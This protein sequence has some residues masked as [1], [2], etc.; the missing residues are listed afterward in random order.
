M[1]SP[2]DATVTVCPTPPSLDEDAAMNDESPREHQ[3]DPNAP[4]MTCD[5]GTLSE[6]HHAPAQEL[7]PASNPLFVAAQETQLPAP[8]IDPPSFSEFICSSDPLEDNIL[9]LTQD[10]RPGLHV[11]PNPSPEPYFGPTIGTTHPTNPRPATA[12]QTMAHTINQ[13][14]P[15]ASH[16][17]TEVAELR[18]ENKEL[19]TITGGLRGDMDRMDNKITKTY[20]LAIDNLERGN[21]TGDLVKFIHLQERLRVKPTPLSKPLPGRPK[22]PIPAM[23]LPRNRTPT[24]SQITTL[25][26]P[27]LPPPP[28]V[29]IISSD[30]DNSQPSPTSSPA[31]ALAPAPTPAPTR[32]QPPRA[33]SNSP[34]SYLE[35][36]PSPPDMPTPKKPC[37]APSYASA[38]QRGFQVVVNK[39]RKSP[40]KSTQPA[41]E[42]STRDRE[43]I[44]TCHHAEPA[45]TPSVV[46]RITE[47]TRKRL[48]RTKCQGTIS[49][50]RTSTKGTLILTSDPHH[51]SNDIWPYKQHIIDALNDTGIGSFDI[52]QNKPRLS[53]FIN[54]ILLTYPD[55]AA[56]PT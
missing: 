51:L 19:R 53:F 14:Y 8:E 48:S 37:P 21:V 32:K 49:A 20:K 11:P 50:I 35:I 1:T 38:A 43:I 46:Q 40:F 55:T 45:I 39:K 52:D 44:V 27:P 33:A 22:S 5:Y 13:I 9:G 3:I 2:V 31:P 4:D 15:L 54:G 16:L 12:L 28:P 7:P 24:T 25:P 30:D 36:H 23:P 6:S 17:K 18:A 10:N 26:A 34:K 42:T 47:S 56:H 41:A 29:F